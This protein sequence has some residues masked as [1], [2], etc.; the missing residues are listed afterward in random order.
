MKHMNDPLRYHFWRLL[1]I[2]VIAAIGI[3]LNSCG[4]AKEKKPEHPP[5]PVEIAEAIQKDTPVY[6]RG[7][8]NVATLNTV[9]VKSRVTGELIKTHFKEGDIV[10][11]GQPLF[12]ID[13]EPFKAKVK[14]AEARANQ[15]RVLYE[16]AQR[17]FQRFKILHSE[18][19]VSQEQLETKQ[20]D[21]NSKQY[22]YDLNQAE[23]ETAKLNLSYC[24]IT[25]PLDGKAGEKYIDTFNI[26][27]ANQDTLVTIRQLRPIKLRFSLPGH[28]LDEIRDYNSKSPLEVEAVVPGTD[29]VETGKLSFI[30]NNIT[31]KTGML[32]LEATLP[33]EKDRLWP[34]L[35]INVKLKLRVAQNAVLIP[36][37]AIVDGPTGQ[38]V[39]LV[40]DAMIV[41][42]RPVKLQMR[43]GDME[44]IADG[45]K[46]GDKV[47]TDGMLMLR[48]GAKVI[49]K[50][51][52]EKA[53]SQQ[54]G[55]PG[56]KTPEKGR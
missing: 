39:W 53:M 46:A 30:D 52:M 56:Q 16:Q 51:A 19:A 37:K 54:H 8:G 1:G 35:F 18:K 49:S 7:I 44:A 45:L 3:S 2:L 15:S 43:V 25:A 11:I 42:M 33:N 40:S 55:G 24:Y 21:M 47:V 41:S 31:L 29:Q 5:I 34:G 10:S 20:V 48:P 36:S 26:V 23:L 4:K 27:N 38:Y 14:E 50:E 6:L 32:N 17:E 22:Q 28:Y 13:P 12:T 9:N